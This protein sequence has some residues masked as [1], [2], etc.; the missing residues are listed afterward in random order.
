MELAALRYLIVDASADARRATRERLAE[1]GCRAV[2]EA[3]GSVAALA[4]LKARRF[5]LVIAS[6]AMPGVSGFDLLNVVRADPAL[7]HLPV[8]MLVAPGCKDDSVRAVQGGAAG[9]LVT[10]FDA[11]AL[12]GTLRGILAR[13]GR[14]VPA[15]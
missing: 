11:A 8:L 9:Y 7:R 2:D 6:A 10:P 12:V 3:A 13:R 5:D 15:A 1:I 4:L 14:P